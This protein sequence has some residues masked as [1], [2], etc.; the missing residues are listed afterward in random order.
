MTMDHLNSHG[1]GCD[2]AVII[3]QHARLGESGIKDLRVFAKRFEG[4]N[5]EVFI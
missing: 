4:K 3:N 1:F 2:N 5:S